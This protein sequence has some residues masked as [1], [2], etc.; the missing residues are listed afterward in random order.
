MGPRLSLLQ[1]AV[2]RIRWCNGEGLSDSVAFLQ[3]DS[4]YIAPYFENDGSAIR[5]VDS[6]RI[7]P[8]DIVGEVHYDGLIFAGAIWDLWELMREEYPEDQAYDQTANI[9]VQGLR[10]GPTIPESFDAMLL[11]D[12]DN[13]NW[14]MEHPINVL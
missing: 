9:F 11:A 10:S 14:T 6:D 8:D 2:R 12:D 13:A 4:P 7:Y 3:T 1:L 5:E